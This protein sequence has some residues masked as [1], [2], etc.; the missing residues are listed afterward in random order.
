MFV[1]VLVVI[2]G[3]AISS[4]T[5]LAYRKV[6][7]PRRRMSAMGTRLVRFV[8]NQ[9]TEITPVNPFAPPQPVVHQRLRALAP[10]ATLF[11]IE[12]LLDTQLLAD[13]ANP[14]DVWLN[15]SRFDAWR[16]TRERRAYLATESTERSDW[17]NADVYHIAVALGIWADSEPYEANLSRNRQRIRRLLAGASTSTAREIR[18]A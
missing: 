16:T 1:L 3:L 14:G 10:S 17:T 6:W 15:I 8:E 2:A 12:S 11:S 9:S 7:R 5:W 18:A 4:A 13:A